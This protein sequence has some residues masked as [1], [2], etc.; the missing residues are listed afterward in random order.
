MKQSSR[1]FYGEWCGMNKEHSKGLG[2]E[3][4]PVSAQTFNSSGIQSATGGGGPG[5]PPPSW[6][7]SVVLMRVLLLLGVLTAYSLG[8]HTTAYYSWASRG[9]LWCITQEFGSIG[10]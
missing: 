4:Q 8:W 3:G 9:P 7:L 1:L 10:F 5:K 2:L 6:E